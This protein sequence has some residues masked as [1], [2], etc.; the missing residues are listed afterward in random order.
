MEWASRFWAKVVKGDGCWTWTG[1]TAN[2]YGV[3]GMKTEHGWRF[4]YAHR[5]SWQIAYGEV[6]TGMSVLHHC[7]NRPCVRPDHLF[8][9]TTQDNLADMRAKGRGFVPKTRSGPDHH[10][11]GRDVR[12]SANPHARLTASDVA[13]IREQAGKVTGAELARRYGVTRSHIGHILRGDRWR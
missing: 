5:L 9:G 6:P 2:G 7:D 10:W 8:L 13:E 3:L 11:F 12:G 4:S 1:A